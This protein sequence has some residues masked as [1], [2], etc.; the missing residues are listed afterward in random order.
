MTACGKLI[1]KS[2]LKKNLSQ[3]DL[4]K[5]LGWNTAQF[6][7]NIERGLAEVP[8]KYVKK[9]SKVLSLDPSELLKSIIVDKTRKIIHAAGL[10]NVRA[11]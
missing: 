1:H 10:T 5:E 8:P 6:V 4:A 2:R 11:S 9:I 7:S 3:A